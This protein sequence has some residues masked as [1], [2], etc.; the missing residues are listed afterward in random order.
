L[1]GR[2]KGY[3]M[4]RS[5][6]AVGDI[7]GYSCYRECWYG[8]ALKGNLQVLFAKGSR[9]GGSLVRCREQVRVGLEPGERLIQV[10]LVARCI[11]KGPWGELG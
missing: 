3:P 10:G 9:V 2:P 7:G 11:E 4:F 1:R 5:G 6:A 8:G